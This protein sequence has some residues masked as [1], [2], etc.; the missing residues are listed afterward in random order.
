MTNGL[1]QGNAYIDAGEDPNELL[2]NVLLMRYGRSGADSDG[3][4]MLWSDKRSA[5]GLIFRGT[6]ALGKR[7]APARNQ[8]G[9]KFGAG[10]GSSRR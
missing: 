7:G 1:Q 3:A 2:E 8:F 5:H 4:E 9:M 10:R 6:G